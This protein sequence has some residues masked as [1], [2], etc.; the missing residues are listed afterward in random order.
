M[1][2]STDSVNAEHAYRGAVLR[3]SYRNTNDRPDRR[4][5]AK[6]PMALL[7]AALLR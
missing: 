1:L 3:E 2:V 6:A 7:A 4:K 5:R